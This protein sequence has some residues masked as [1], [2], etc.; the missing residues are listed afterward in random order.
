MGKKI[1]GV[2]PSRFW[3]MIFRPIDRI[4]YLNFILGD[5]PVPIVNIYK[6]SHSI[7]NSNRS[8]L[9]S[10][11]VSESNFTKTPYF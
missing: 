8:Y 10:K 9:I 11:N 4:Q 7:V 1:F 2:T 6:N 5:S 3:A